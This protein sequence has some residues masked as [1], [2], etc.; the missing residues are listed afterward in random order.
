MLGLFVHVVGKEGEVSV[1]LGKLCQCDRLFKRVTKLVAK[2]LVVFVEAVKMLY[3]RCMSGPTPLR[4][5]V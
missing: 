3:L 1:C 5:V 2:V 4:Q